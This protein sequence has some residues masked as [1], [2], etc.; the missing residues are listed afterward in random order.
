[1]HTQSLQKENNVTQI[2]LCFTF[3]STA[4]QSFEKQGILFTWPTLKPQLDRL[5]VNSWGL[6]GVCN[7]NAND[8]MID[9]LW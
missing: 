2:Q 4:Y 7:S 6:H 8:R 1:M 9:C 5:T 3:D